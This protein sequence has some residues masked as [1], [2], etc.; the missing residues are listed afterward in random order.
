MPLLRLGDVDP[1]TD[2]DIRGVLGDGVRSRRDEREI[3]RAREG[4]ATRPRARA[5]ARSGARGARRGRAR[6][7]PVV[8]DLLIRGAEARVGRLRH[9][10]R[11]I[12]GARPDELVDLARR[13][14]VRGRE[15]IGIRD[16][17]HE[18]AILRSRGVAALASRRED[19]LDVARKVTRR[20]G[21]APPPAPLPE[22]VE[23]V[24]A[25]RP[26]DESKRRATRD[27]EV[28]GGKSSV[29]QRTS[30]GAD[31]RRRPRDTASRG[32]PRRWLS[33]P[34][35][36]SSPRAYGSAAGGLQRSGAEGCDRRGA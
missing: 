26:R 30:Q 25:K 16:E 11:G 24:Q 9:R 20:G 10:P 13:I 2:V 15:E 23:L 32:A 31:Q 8:E 27:S 1:I 22:P 33:A 14:G 18:R 7:D 36:R 29:H 4:F 35:Y 17:R 12:V 3:R 28:H 34:A 19:G 5:G 6:R 21:A